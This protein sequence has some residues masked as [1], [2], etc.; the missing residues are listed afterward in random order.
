MNKMDTNFKYLV[1]LKNFPLI[2]LQLLL[3]SIGQLNKNNST[4]ILAKQ[5]IVE[6]H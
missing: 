3:V 2:Y 6:N 4:T 5:S 1:P